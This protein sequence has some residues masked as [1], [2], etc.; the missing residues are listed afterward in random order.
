[1]QIRLPADKCNHCHR[2]HH[3]STVGV[4]CQQ[5]KKGVGGWSVAIKRKNHRGQLPNVEWCAS[6]VP[7]TL[8]PLAAETVSQPE[9]AAAAAM[10]SSQRLVLHTSYGIYRHRL[11]V[12]SG[13]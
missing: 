2:H 8:L 1:M 4:A 11:V 7:T 12:T 13:F 5:R 9:P 6:W 10:L 3:R